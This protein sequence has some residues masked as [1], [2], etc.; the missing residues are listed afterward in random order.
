MTVAE[1]EKIPNRRAVAVN[2]TLSPIYTSTRR[3]PLV[4][5][6]EAV[7]RSASSPLCAELPRNTTYENF[8]EL[9]Q[10]EVRSIHLLGTLVNKV[11]EGFGGWPLYTVWMRPEAAS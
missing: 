4:I 6:P 5:M 8:L 1:P 7:S 10:C 3:P 11:I 2:S 9:R